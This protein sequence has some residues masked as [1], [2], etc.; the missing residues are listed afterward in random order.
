M[1][2]EGASLVRTSFWIQSSGL[3]PKFPDSGTFRCRI[4]YVGFN[5]K[6]CKCLAR[7]I[8]LA[9]YGQSSRRTCFV[10]NAGKVTAHKVCGY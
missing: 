2:G 6:F 5:I 1:Q 4:D 10:L 7:G 9:G 8:T 3:H